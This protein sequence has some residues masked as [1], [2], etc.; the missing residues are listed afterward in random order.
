MGRP[1][2]KILDL[3]RIIIQRLKHDSYMSLNWPASG[4][5]MESIAV[6][7]AAEFNV[8]Q[9]VTLHQVKRVLYQLTHDG[10]APHRGQA[11]DTALHLGPVR[12][13]WLLAHGGKQPVIKR[14]VD[15][16]MKAEAFLN[17]NGVGPVLG[18]IEGAIFYGEKGE[19]AR[20]ETLR[21]W[22]KGPSADEE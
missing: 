21:L 14:L 4:T 9:E 20:D 17:G 15:E 22:A 19:R 16:A 2:R 12:C 5:M 11:N 6:D 1:S 8:T 7:L 13:A 18:V 3:R 10:K